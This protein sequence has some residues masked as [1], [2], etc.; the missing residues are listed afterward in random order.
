LTENIVLAFVQNIKG[1]IIQL[2]TFLAEVVLIAY[3][4]QQWLV[5]FNA[6][7]GQVLFLPITRQLLERCSNPLRICEVF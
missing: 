6:C 1:M 4:Q 7:T 3:Y 5:P 2:K